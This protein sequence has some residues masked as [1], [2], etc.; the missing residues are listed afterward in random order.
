MSMD[1][2]DSYDSVIV[3]IFDDQEVDDEDGVSS[4]AQV[5]DGKSW[6]VLFLKADANT[7]N[8]HIKVEFLIS[9]DGS[10]FSAPLTAAD[11]VLIADFTSTTEVWLQFTLPPC[12]EWKL[13]IT[14]L[15]TNGSDIDLHADV[16]LSSTPQYLG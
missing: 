2:I 4:S 14:G 9:Y 3:E 12:Q 8:A 16:V 10:T 5:Y 15:G 6:V 1:R 11:G 7:G 13:K